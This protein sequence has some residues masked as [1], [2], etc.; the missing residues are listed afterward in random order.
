MGNQC[1]GAPGDENDHHTV[2]WN[3]QYTSN[4]LRRSNTRRPTHAQSTTMMKLQ[5]DKDMKI[6]RVNQY[7]MVKQ[8]GKGSFGDVY[9]ASEQSEKFAVKV[10]K[11]SALRR[12]RQG[13]FGSA[14]D[15]VK[16]EIALMKKI[17]HP[18]CVGMVEVIDDPK[19]DE[20][21]I[22]LEFVDGGASQPIGKDGLPVRLKEATIWSHM[23][24]LVL[25][26]EYL[27][28]NG[29]VHRDIKPENLLVSRCAA[30]ARVAGRVH[31]MG[32]ALAWTRGGLSVWRGPCHAA[33]REDQRLGG[34]AGGVNGL[35]LRACGCC[36]ALADHCAAHPCLPSPLGSG[37]CLALCPPSTIP[38]AA[39]RAQ[40]WRRHAQ[41]RGLWHRA[42][43][44]G[45][46][47]RDPQ[48]GRHASLLRARDVRARAGGNV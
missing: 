42:L 40:G 25:G 44:R 15:T 2:T 37:R 8:L 17:R 48:D 38:S 20:V 47:G 13:R 7:E 24:H 18:N 23:R 19:A 31:A 12:Q 14:L 46:G 21:F 32:N 39:V 9:L 27:H 43:R 29:I 36:P 5:R 41:D 11:K 22:V 1:V 45:L 33:F 26:L 28:M 3:T 30:C 6:Q 35:F 16:A 4:A 34:A 10:L